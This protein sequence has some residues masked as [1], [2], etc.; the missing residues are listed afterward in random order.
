MLQEYL[1]DAVYV[2]FD[3]YQLRLKCEAMSEAG[4]IYLEPEVWARLE[5]FVNRIKKGLPDG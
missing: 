2:S 1:G 3:G 4:V 5:N